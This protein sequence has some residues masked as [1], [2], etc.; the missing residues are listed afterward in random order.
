MIAAAAAAGENIK[1][2]G[3]WPQWGGPDRN[4]TIK[5]A[6]LAPE[7]P[8]GGPRVL[9][10]RTLGTGYSAISM[11]DGK[12]FTMYRKSKPD[13]YEYTI[14]MDA[15]SGKTLW[16]KR[17]MAAVPRETADHGKE[18]SGPNATPLIVGDRLYTIGRN[19]AL[20]CYNKAD[21]KIL[22]S[23][24]LKRSFG[25]QIETCGYSC[26]PLAYGNT[27]IVPVGRDE[28][29][30]S[31]GE[32]LVAFDQKSGDVVWK[33]HTFR[34]CHSSPILINLGGE[35]Q[36]VLCTKEGVIGVSPSDGKLLW[37]L[38]ISEEQFAGAFASPVWNGVDTLYC[39][40]RAYGFGIRLSKSEGKTTPEQLWSS[41]RTPLGMGTPVLVGDMLVGARRGTTM[42]PPMIGVDLKTGERLWYERVFPQA[43]VLSA[44]EKLIVLDHR[45]N[46]GLATATREG[47]T[48]HSQF[49]ATEQYSF[50]VP[51]IV[52][53]TL[54]LRD[55]KRIMAFDLSADTGA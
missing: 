51:T 18:F 34:I 35:D 11:D 17:N 47:L 13:V 23:K 40:S 12:L 3:Q 42:D 10:Q 36:Y 14:A 41:R 54:Y 5:A 38:S 37:Q 49:Q 39:A 30:Q 43:V 52:G 55:E 26:S 6:E 28:G 32:S 44:G 27:V 46:L 50:T 9:W 7:W 45:G 24:K 48:V 15:A 2:F 20:H 31:E 22:W 19:A 21:G 29:S 8:A 16:Q 1:A 33:N 25:A 4:F 53:K